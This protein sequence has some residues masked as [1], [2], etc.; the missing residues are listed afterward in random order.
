MTRAMLVTVLWRYAGQPEEGENTFT[1]VPSGRWYSKAIAWAAHNGI[2][3]GVGNGRF[4]PDGNITREQMATILYR[5]ATMLELNTSLKGDIDSFS[6]VNS[7][8]SFAVKGMSWAVAEGLIKG[9][10]DKLMPKGNAT[11]AQVAV[12]LMRFVENVVEL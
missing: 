11:R 8:S 9:A 3:S 6:D 10:D 7:I 2:V 5:Y 12:I 1:D 4:N